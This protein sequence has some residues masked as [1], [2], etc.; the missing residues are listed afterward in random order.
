MDYHV[1]RESNNP[2][3]AYDTI[4]TFTQ[5]VK[6]FDLYLNLIESRP[7]C[8][9]CVMDSNGKLM[10]EHDPCKIGD[11]LRDLNDCSDI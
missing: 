9:T 7:E 10:L 4:A 3:K 5:Y 6:A 2:E 1:K 11:Y 8:Y